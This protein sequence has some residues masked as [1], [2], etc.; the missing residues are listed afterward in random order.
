MFKK[1][2][3]YFFTLLVNMWLVQHI[4]S[5]QN[6]VTKS[7][8]Y[9]ITIRSQ[10]SKCIH[11]SSNTKIWTLM[12]LLYFIYIC[13]ILVLIAVKLQD[14]QV[15]YIHLWTG[16]IMQCKTSWNWRCIYAKHFFSDILTV[17]NKNIYSPSLFK[18]LFGNHLKKNSRACFSL[19]S[20]KVIIRCI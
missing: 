8:P 5:A 13:I 1:R 18:F 16:C 14:S 9:F 4:L 19:Y 3:K 20:Y 2:V 10:I 11:A 6:Y 17:N 12:F 7:L 15:L